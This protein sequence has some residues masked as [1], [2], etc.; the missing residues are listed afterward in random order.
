M[1]NMSCSICSICSLY[2]LTGWKLKG[3]FEGQRSEYGRQK[4]VHKKGKSGSAP[5]PGWSTRA[6]WRWQAFHYLWDNIIGRTLAEDTIVSIKYM[7]NYLVS[8]LVSL[9]MLCLLSLY[10][11][12]HYMSLVIICYLLF[13]LA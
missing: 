4:N 8:F 7:N 6:K 11:S 12:C 2:I 9:C 5:M 3:W 13:S 1:F 10:V